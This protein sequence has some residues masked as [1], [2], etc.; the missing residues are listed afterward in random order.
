MTCHRWF[1]LLF[2]SAIFIGCDKEE[3]QIADSLMRA[4][5][6][7]ARRTMQ[8]PLAA[9]DLPADRSI[10]S[11]DITLRE[12]TIGEIGELGWSMSVTMMDRKQIEG[13][14]PRLEISAG[15]PFYV[16]DL[17]LEGLEPGSPP[18]PDL[19]EPRWPEPG[20]LY[21]LIDE[22][23]AGQGSGEPERFEFLELPVAANYLPAGRK[24]RASDIGFYPMTSTQIEQMYLPDFEVM[25]SS[26]QFIGRR[27]RKPVALG[28]PFLLS[29]FH[30]DES[31]GQYLKDR[32]R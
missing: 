30:V 9:S 27:L 24:I 18:E 17:Y 29:D 13:R 6:D 25:L 12:M 10:G 28:D 4:E 26:E 7:F 20:A 23:P 3:Q 31:V 22:L 2:T 11:A 1:A 8:I 5:E 16:T 14:V 21:L 15:A 19:P 32:Q